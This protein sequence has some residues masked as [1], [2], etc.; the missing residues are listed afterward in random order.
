MRPTH[1][2]PEHPDGGDQAFLEAYDPDAF[3][4]PSLAVDVALITVHEG[5]LLCLLHRRPERPARG[6]WALPGGFVGMQESLDDAARR[7]L[8]SKASLTEV[9]LEQLYTFGNPGRDPRTRVVSVAYYALV[10][11]GRLARALEERADLCLAR[12]EVP[13]EGERGDKVG[14]RGA[15]DERLR[16]AFDHDSILGVLVARLR[17]KLDY[18]RL[19]FELLPD[20]FTLRELQTVHEVVL[21]RELNKDSFRRRLLATGRLV[22]TGEREHDVLHRPAEL[23]RTQDPPVHR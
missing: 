3:P 22:P 7:V 10:D 13:W 20:R 9:F 19:G 21:G 11:H 23:Y 12:L 14:A 4:H 8:E 16:L 1:T 18:A 2:E 5:E 15:R 17:G 6:S